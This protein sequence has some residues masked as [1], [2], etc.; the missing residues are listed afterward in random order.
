[1]WQLRGAQQKPPFHY[2]P[3]VA[4]HG[5]CY[6]SSIMRH[7]KQKQEVAAVALQLDYTGV[8]LN[9]MLAGFMADSDRSRI[10]PLELSSV[11][12]AALGVA[13]A[14]K[15]HRSLLK[16]PAAQPF[17]QFSRITVAVDDIVQAA[18]LNA[19]N[20]I[21]HSY[22]IVAVRPKN[23]KAFNQASTHLEVKRQKR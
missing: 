11:I 12:A 13:E 22:E 3:V 4:A 8:A 6:C 9:H 20:Q 23:Q 2:H 5:Y 16:A 18:A 15:F 17:R 14:A 19:V 7:V 1:L 10:K 21:L